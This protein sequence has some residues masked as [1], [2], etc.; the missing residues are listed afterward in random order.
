M[1]DPELE[2]LV[3]GDIL[4]DRAKSHRAETFLRFREGE[5][6][7]GEVDTMADRFANGLAAAGVRQ[8][9]HVAVMLPNCADIV[10][11][12]FALARLG[13][14]AVPINIDYRGE[15]LRHVLASSDASTLIVDE[16]YA[17]RLPPLAERLPGLDR[18]LVRTEGTGDVLFDRLGVP[19]GPMS[20]LLGH[21]DEPVSSDVGFSDLLAI[22]Y[23]SGTTGPSKG[24]MVPHALALTC[25]LDSL[26][27]L[28]RWGKTVYCPLPLFHA[29]GLWDGMMAAL[30]SGSEIAIVER[31]SASRFWDDVR[32]FDAKSRWACSR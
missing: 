18:V 19:A 22:M 4:R 10:H 27:F 8:G 21:G 14:V 2:G 5:I 13:A 25:A 6:T 23:T 20:G 32:R 15:P 31:F 24:A 26:N 11:V 7:Y 3:L 17:D 9:D 30:L 12:V 16:A 1:T 29:A 28:D